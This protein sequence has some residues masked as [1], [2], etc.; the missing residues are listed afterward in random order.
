MH[1]KGENKPLKGQFLKIFGQNQSEVNK[2][3]RES[4]VQSEI[5]VKNRRGH[6][7]MLNKNLEGF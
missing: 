6:V 1:E 4:H 7:K 5:A 3:R 2:R